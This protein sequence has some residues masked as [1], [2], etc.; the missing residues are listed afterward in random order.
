MRYPCVL[1]TLHS[2][3]FLPP[4]LVYSPST[5]LR[6]SYTPFPPP[7]HPELRSELHSLT[8]VGLLIPP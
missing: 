8:G 3:L 4:R 7:P 5:N 2:L 6:A 1:E